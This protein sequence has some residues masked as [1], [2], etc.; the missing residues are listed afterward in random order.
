MRTTCVE[1]GEVIMTDAKTTAERV[2]GWVTPRDGGGPNHVRFIKRLGVFA[3]KAC[4]ETA[5]GW[6]QPQSMFDPE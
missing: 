3:H 2:E 5:K 6:G 4:V 1:C